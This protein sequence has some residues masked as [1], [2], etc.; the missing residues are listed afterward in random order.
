MSAFARRSPSTLGVLTL[1][2]CLASV[3]VES[4]IVELTTEEFY[5]RVVN[6]QYDV[7]LDVR[8]AAEFAAGH[9]EG[10]SLV[11]SMASA[12]T[13]ELLSGCQ[14]CTILIYDMSGGRADIAAMILDL[15]GYIGIHDGGGTSAWILKGYPLVAGSYSVP[16]PCFRGIAGGLGQCKAL[17]ATTP[18]PVVAFVPP[19]VA[20]PTVPPVAAL[21]ALPPTAPPVIAL[22]ATT[23][24]P[25][26]LG[27]IFGTPA[28]LGV[29]SMGC[30]VSGA[31][32][33]G[34]KCFINHCVVN[35]GITTPTTGFGTPNEA[36]PRPGCH[37]KTRYNRQ[38][39]LGQ[40]HSKQEATPDVTR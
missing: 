27:L 12:G 30:D 18:P 16:I 29:D 1:L 13:H 19:P 8:T 7:L 39:R 10:A 38:L 23:P 40:R 9:I 33:S 21:P 6:K 3:F 31:C 26:D 37:K 35:T 20:Y 34:L 28:C 11:E 2:V 22:P 5:Y 15:E 17:P 36:N 32:C 14:L 4:V 24:P 25:V